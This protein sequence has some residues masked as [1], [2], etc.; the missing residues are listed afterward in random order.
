MS[1]TVS[2]NL[3]Q[4]ELAQG[5]FLPV[6]LKQRD[7]SSGLFRVVNGKQ[8]VILQAMA[9]QND[10]QVG[11]FCDASFTN[12]DNIAEVQLPLIQLNVKRKHCKEDLIATHFAV[13]MQRGT[14]NDSLVTEVM[15]S[16]TTSILGVLN[17]E[18]ARLRW[19]GSV[20]TGDAMDGVI[21]KAQSLG[22]PTVAAAAITPTN[23]IA[24]IQKVLDA[25]PAE[26][27]YSDGFK[28]VVSPAIASAYQA[29]TAQNVGLATWGVGQNADGKMGNAYLGLYAGT[30]VPMYLVPQ[31]AGT[32]N[33][34]IMLAGVM[35]DSPMSN[36]V[37]GTDA[38]LDFGNVVVFDAQSVNPL[39]NNVQFGAAIRQAVHIMDATQMVLYI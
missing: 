28:L 16:I 36:L 24:E 27:R 12:T 39:D 8:N 6:L 7:L 13:Q 3:F 21:T 1:F 29:A 4:G 9:H 18:A 32:T 15:T 35:E 38:L 11:S 25:T 17:N 33:A 20:A 14:F 23:V 26:V 5:I 10:I 2:P 34:A 31:L 30:Q 37:L 22:V 19:I